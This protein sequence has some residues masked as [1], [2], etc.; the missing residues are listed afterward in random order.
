MDK[1]CHVFK[2]RQIFDSA[3]IHN[4]TWRNYEEVQN[5]TEN[6]KKLHDKWSFEILR[7]MI[8]VVRRGYLLIEAQF[9]LPQVELILPYLDYCCRDTSFIP[10]AVYDSVIIDLKLL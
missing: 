2:I 4:D 6:N 7:T 3:I 5:L 10:G 1:L 8:S 9:W